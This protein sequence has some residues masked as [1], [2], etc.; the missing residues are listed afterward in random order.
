MLFSGFSRCPE[1]NHQSRVVER[2]RPITV[3][4]VYT[5]DPKH[6]V[7]PVQISSS[8]TPS[9]SL[10]KD[11]SDRVIARQSTNVSRG[12]SGMGKGRSG[13]S[14]GWCASQ[15]GTFAFSRRFA[16]LIII[17]QDGTRDTN[18]DIAGKLPFRLHYC[19][20]TG[21]ELPLCSRATVGECKP[22][23]YGMQ[24]SE[25]INTSET[26]VNLQTHAPHDLS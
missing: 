17:F 7:Y 14:S 23:S 19:P 9:L 13:P 21:W 11:Y 25:R 15:R 18:G 1:V 24:R 6:K 10:Q 16:C 5:G 20:N 2:T 3:L 4:T 22:A 8:V 26:W 12:A